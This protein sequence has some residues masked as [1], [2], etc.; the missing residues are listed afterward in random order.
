MLQKIRRRDLIILTGLFSLAGITVIVM[1]LLIMRDANAYRT[2]GTTPVSQPKPTHTVAF[3]EITGLKQ[4]QLAK[5]AALAWSA[6][7]QLIAASTTWPRVISLEQVGEPSEWTY[8]FYSPSKARKL[9]VI[10]QPDNQLEVIQHA[11][12]VTLPPNII[13]SDKWLLDSPE[14]LAI[15]LDNGG[16]Q[17]IGRNPGS[18]IVIQLRGDKHS[19]EPVWL[20][21][22]LSHQTNETASLVIDAA[23][24]RVIR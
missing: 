20:V 5:E 9:F 6:D 10:V 11:V 12:I 1:G 19:F 3:R 17:L 8:H 23:T 24:G 15:W 22:G 4:Y 14:A 18:E 13:L 2:E 21:V 7:A 16:R